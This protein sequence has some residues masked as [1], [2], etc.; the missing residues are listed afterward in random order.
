MNLFY[1]SRCIP[2]KQWS[3]KN[4]PGFTLNELL[5]SV[6]IL[7]ILL[8][9]AIPTYYK[10]VPSLRL[11]RAA[12]ELYTY[13]HLAKSAAIRDNIAHRIVFDLTK[14]RENYSIWSEGPNRQ[15][16]D[17][18]KDDVREKIIRLA[19][20]GEEI[21][22]GRG[23]AKFDA[24]VHKGKIPDDGISYQDN[25]IRFHPIGTVGIYGYV[26][27]RNRKGENYAVGSPVLAGIIVL[28]KWAGEN[29]Q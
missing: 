29:W 14:G 8:T 15:W 17:Q 20:Y 21:S 6:S 27:L 23:A 16:D 28:K 2:R 25:E 9:I 7:A 19:E 12:R 24:T 11:R 10:R 26:Y 13:M 22:F 4:S 1:K 3:P 5:V 18:G